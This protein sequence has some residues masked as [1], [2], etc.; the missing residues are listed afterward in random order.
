MPD[1]DTIKDSPIKPGLL[2]IWKEKF[3]VIILGMD[4]FALGDHAAMA[5]DFKGEGLF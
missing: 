5:V 1:D 3:G 2:F 4:R